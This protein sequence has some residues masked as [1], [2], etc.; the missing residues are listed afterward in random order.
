MWILGIMHIIHMKLDGILNSIDYI[1][2]EFLNG[3]PIYFYAISIFFDDIKVNNNLWSQ[4][5][6]F[7]L[8]SKWKVYCI[9][10]FNITQYLYI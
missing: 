8:V 5:V 10:R 4:M 9:K 2:F 1:G 6:E 3:F 7:Y